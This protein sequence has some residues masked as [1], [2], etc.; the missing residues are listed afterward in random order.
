MAFAVLMSAGASAQ[1][2]SS[3]T[4]T[5]KEGSGYNRLSLSYNSVS[6]LTEDA[7]SGVSL[8]WTKGISISKATPLFIE[9]GI[10]LNYAWDSEDDWSLHFLTAT[11]PVNL[12]YKWEIP[13][14]DIRLAPFAGIYFRGNLVA[15]SGTDDYMINWFN[16]KP[17]ENDY[18]DK[19][20]DPEDYG[21]EASRFSFGW[22]IGVGLEYSKFYVGLSYGSDLT[23]LVE[24]ADKIGTFSATVGFNF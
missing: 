9:T 19:D 24:K 20:F 17:S 6:N 11:V 22:N 23:E 8:A 3:N 16:D 12:V 21:M 2:I 7:T 18:Y 10:G 5:H 4:V 15:E 1:L 14:T 13:N